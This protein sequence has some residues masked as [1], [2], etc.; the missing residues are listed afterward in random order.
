MDRYE[1]ALEIIARMISDEDVIRDG[2]L[3]TERALSE[4][5]GIG[6]RVLRRAL[7]TLELDGKIVRHQGRGTFVAGWD[8]D[9][10]GQSRSTAMQ[11]SNGKGLA[12]LLDIAN[13]IE[14]IELRLAIEPIM[15]RWA[16]LRSSRLDVDN[17]CKQADLTQHADNHVA[18]QEADS[19][20]H[21]MIA[22]FSRN[23]AFIELQAVLSTALHDSALE[24]FGEN[25]HCFKRQSEH[26]AYHHAIV[27]AIAERDPKAAERLMREHLTDVHSSIFED[28]MTLGHSA[29]T[30]VAAE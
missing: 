6:R 23:S 10:A 8:N 22:E 26:V 15:C 14:L 19:T 21:R 18:Y 7:Q 11:K 2:R 27:E 17:L 9:S 5:L 13:P 1:E 20:F 29:A 30:E 12:S 3:P 24:R 25:G 16:A 28:A 4:Q